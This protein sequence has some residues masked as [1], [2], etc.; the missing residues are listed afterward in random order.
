M[1][2]Y[3]DRSRIY[4]HEMKIRRRNVDGIIKIDHLLFITGAHA[5]LLIYRR[6]LSIPNIF[7]YRS[8]VPAS[9]Y[10]YIY[11]HI[12][13]LPLYIISA[14]YSPYH[15]VLIISIM[16]LQKLSNYSAFQGT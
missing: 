2:R 4:S 9:R 15:Y 5:L 16:Y 3:K 11:V 6:Y 8:N 10:T 1:Y 12:G 13:Y 7:L 14:I